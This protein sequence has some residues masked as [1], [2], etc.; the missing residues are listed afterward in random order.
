MFIIRFIKNFIQNRIYQKALNKAYN[1]DDIIAKLSNIFGVQFRKDWIG[2][3]YSVINP[4]I[5]D[6]KFD[7][8]QVFEYAEAGIDTTE[9]ARVWMVQRMLV[10]QKFV[11][12]ENLFDI[13]TYDIKRIDDYG[14]YLLTIFPITLPDVLSSI[15]AALIEL[16]VMVGVIGGIFY[17]FL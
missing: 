11:Q 1:Q 17:Y 12:T 10:F 6:G 3:L 16:I 13:L 8:E 4:G 15:R 9:H 2:R 14:N 7:Q 5:R